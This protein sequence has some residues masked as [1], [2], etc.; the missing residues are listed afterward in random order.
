MS[1]LI[2][3]SVADLYIRVSTEEQAEKGGYQ[4]YQEEV[5]RRYCE[6]NSIHVKS[7][8]YEDFSA[9]TFN[10]SQTDGEL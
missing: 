4:H 6:A 8:I 9:K 1:K 5:L 2:K 3:L 10:R 7:V